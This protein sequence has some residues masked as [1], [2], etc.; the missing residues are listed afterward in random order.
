[1]RHSRREQFRQ[2]VYQICMGY[3]DCNEAEWLRH[4]PAFQL[5]CDS[6]RHGAVTQRCHQLR[7]SRSPA[8]SRRS[9]AASTVLSASEPWTGAAFT[10][11]LLGNG[12]EMR[13][14]VLVSASRSR[15]LV[16]RAKGQVRVLRS[17][18]VSRR[19]RPTT[20]QIVV[21]EQ[22]LRTSAVARP[23]STSPVY[24]G[25]LSFPL[26][27]VSWRRVALIRRFCCLRGS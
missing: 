14:R 8:S 12:L 9:L 22:A 1:M 18:L 25:Q 6:G 13:L 10:S 21:V 2:R 3:D 11:T 4:D 26:H 17:P 16:L 20:A 19:Q 15:E 27:W 5:A 7:R 24:P 23:G